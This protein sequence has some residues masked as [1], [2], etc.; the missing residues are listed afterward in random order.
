LEFH[1]Y[2]TYIDDARSNTNQVYVISPLNHNFNYLAIKLCKLYVTVYIAVTSG[3]RK[4]SCDL[5]ESHKLELINVVWLLFGDMWHVLA[6]YGAWGSVVVKVL[7][8]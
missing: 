1:I 4:T 6:H 3:K 8:Y 2:F 5:R 7:R